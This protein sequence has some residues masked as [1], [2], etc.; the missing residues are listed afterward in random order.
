MLTPPPPAIC[1]NPALLILN[2]AGQRWFAAGIPN[3]SAQHRPAGLTYASCMRGKVLLAAFALAAFSCG[4][5]LAQDPKPKHGGVMS[6]GDQD[7]YAELVAEAHR[8]VVYVAADDKPISGTLRR[9]ARP[10]AP[11]QSVTLNAA[12]DNTLSASGLKLARGDQVRA[13]VRISDGREQTFA[14]T[15]W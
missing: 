2:G 13:Y 1:N 3:S 10:R 15:Y 5:A 7:I 4:N 11:E 12:G 9:L 8:L 14:F 6:R